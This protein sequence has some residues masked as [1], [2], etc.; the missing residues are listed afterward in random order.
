MLKTQLLR[1]PEQ[2]APIQEEMVREVAEAENLRCQPA[3]SV[4]ANR[5]QQHTPRDRCSEVNEM[6]GTLPPPS[7]LSA[8]KTLSPQRHACHLGD[9]AP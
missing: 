4:P 7:S 1:D 8:D 5:M 9:T 6:M 3:C 2:E